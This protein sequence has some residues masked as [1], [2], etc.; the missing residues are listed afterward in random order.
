MTSR[1]A[2]AA[3]CR[4]L[5]RSLVDT[6]NRRDDAAITLRERTTLSEAERAR[7]HTRHDALV[8]EGAELEIAMTEAARAWAAQFADAERKPPRR[9]EGRRAR[10]T[11]PRNV[12]NLNLF[13]EVP[14]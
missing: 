8:T 9:A 14:A 6:W 13:D 4:S 3:R 2:L 1:R 12:N 5:S 7:L 10:A 11:M